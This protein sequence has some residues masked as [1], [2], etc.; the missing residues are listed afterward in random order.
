MPSEVHVFKRQSEYPLNK[1]LVSHLS[2]N[3]LCARDFLEASK[4]YNETFRPLIVRSALK[5]DQLN[6]ASVAL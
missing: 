3:L 1:Y 5:Q 2:G 4:A 6:G